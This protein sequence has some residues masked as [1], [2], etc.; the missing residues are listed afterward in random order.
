MWILFA[1]GASFFWGMSYVISEE[2][3]KKISV[4]TALTVTSFAVFLLAL[5]IAYFTGNLKP[6]LVEIASSKKLM[7]Y[8]IAGILVLLIAELFIGFSIVS[9]N[10][11]LAGL[12]E[13]SYPI[14]IALFSYILYKSSITLPT[15]V[16][17]IVIFAGIFIIYYFNH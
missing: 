3:Y 12:I 4:F 10:A 17:G 1:L 14:F 7:W 16:G 11:T 13:I 8:V 6:D 2:I 5:V 9:K 15:V